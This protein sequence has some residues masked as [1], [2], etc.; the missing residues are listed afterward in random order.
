MNMRN[1]IASA[2]AVLAAALFTLGAFQSAWAVDFRNPRA[3]RDLTPALQ[4]SLTDKVSDEA[5]PYFDEQDRKKAAGKPYVD[6]QQKFEYLPNYG[7]HNQLVVS[8]KLGGVEYDPTKAGSSKG[9]STGT[10]RYLVFTYALEKGGWVE[11]TKPKWEQ[12]ALGAKAGAQMTRNQA[13][14][15]QRAAAI[16]K[17]R[18]TKAAA[19]AAAAAAQKAA[20]Q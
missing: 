16:E 19:A 13:R 11:M 12:Q 10:L 5:G 7:P 9:A 20:N 1:S 14:G 4:R 15:D 6:L 18:Q 2:A 17:A 8:V 3:Q